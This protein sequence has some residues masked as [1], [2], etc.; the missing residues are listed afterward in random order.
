M[1]GITAVQYAGFHGN[2][3]KHSRRKTAVLY[4]VVGAALYV[5]FLET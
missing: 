2:A 5:A 3:A 4:G 1:R